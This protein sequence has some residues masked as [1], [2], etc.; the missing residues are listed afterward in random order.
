MGSQG[1]A[2]QEIRTDGNWLWDRT[3]TLAIKHVDCPLF[4][5]YDPFCVWQHVEKPLCEPNCM[6]R[7]SIALSALAVAFFYVAL[8][9]QKQPLHA[10]WFPLL[11]SDFIHSSQRTRK[12]AEFE[13]FNSPRC[14]STEVIPPLQA[15][16]SH[17]LSFV[18]FLNL[19]FQWSMFK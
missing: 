17:H 16:F 13:A 4:P 15:M 19:F 1:T 3:Q 5:L 7:K 10:A 8:E 12:V 11:P 18:T 14:D 2:Q 9:Q 6:D